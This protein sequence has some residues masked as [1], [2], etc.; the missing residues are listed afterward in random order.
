MTTITPLRALAFAGTV[1]AFSMIGSSKASA[2]AYVDVRIGPSGPPPVIVEHPWARP[3]RGAVWIPGS[4]AWR[5]G[6]YVWVGG[7]YAY[8]PHRGGAWVPA[9]YVRRNGVYYYRPGHWA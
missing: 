9:R 8:P 6:R 4:Y 1:L 5:G 7:Y 2:A 3:Y